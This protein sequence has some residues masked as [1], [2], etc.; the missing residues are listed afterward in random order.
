[1]LPFLAHRHEMELVVIVAMAA[2]LGAIAIAIPIVFV[3]ARGVEVAL[4]AAVPRARALSSV[5]APF[6]ALAVMVG[7]GLAIWAHRE[8]ATAQLLP[9]RAPMIAVVAAALAIPAVRPARR[10]YA[11]LSLLQPWIGRSAWTAGA[12]LLAV[13]VLATGGSAQVIKAEMAYTGLGGSIARTLRRAFDWDHDGYSRFLGGGDCDDSDPNVHPG[14]PEIPDD[15]IDQNCVG[16]DASAKHSQSD[17]AFA[18]VPPS[19]PKD[20]NVLL[21]TIDTTRA[22]HLGMYGYNRPTSPNLDKLAADGTV[23]DNGWAHAPSTR[24]SMP[25]ILTG[26]LPLD[27]YY[28]YSINWPGLLPRATTIA[29]LLGPLGMFTGAI[30][31][32]EYFDKSRHMD[33]GFAEYDN[34]D[35]RLH[36]GVAGAGPE[37]THG[38][39]SKEQTDKAIA[40][41]DRHAAS[42]GSCG[43]TTTIRTTRTSRTAR[44]RASAPIAWRSTTARSASPT[45]TSAACSTD[46][47]ASSCSTRRSSS[48]PAIT[49]RASA[50]T[51]SCATAI[52]CTRRRPRCRS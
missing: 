35:A 27:V 5:W 2:A 44:C 19:V 13:L 1:M 50:S 9:L 28:D 22:D 30:T 39:S 21:I 11:L 34:E 29:E 36:Q 52:T 31:N 6:V 45:C 18:P 4:R 7:I 25:A 48:S 12:S 23:F 14:A 41:V 38:S 10:V 46:C 32:F 20:F 33:Q 26:R 17:I 40:F 51:A 15:G 43:C 3:V 42:A 37:Q 8:W 24:Y 47:A 49:A 16:G